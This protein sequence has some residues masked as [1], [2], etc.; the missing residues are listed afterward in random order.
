MRTLFICFAM[1]ALAVALPA[2]DDVVPETSQLT[3]DPQLQSSYNDAEATIA[4]LLQSGKDDSACAD[5]ATATKDEVTNSVDAQQKTLASMDN[6]DQCDGEGQSLIDAANSGKTAADQAKTDAATALAAAENE[7]FNFG[8]FSI[9]QLT[10]G[11]CGSFFNSG[12]YTAAKAKRDA[13]QQVVNTKNAEATAGDKEVED[14]KAAA[15]DLVKKCKC[16]TKE[17]VDK[18]LKEMNANAKDANQKAWNKAYHM[19]CVLAGTSPNDCSVPALPVVTA[20]PYGAGVKDACVQKVQ[21]IQNGC[22]LGGVPGQ[23]NCCKTTDA[24]KFACISDKKG[25]EYSGTTIVTEQTCTE[26]GLK[27]AL[28]KGADNGLFKGTVKGLYKIASGRSCTEL[29]VQQKG[30]CGWWEIIQPNVQAQGDYKDR[31]VTPWDCLQN[32]QWNVGGANPKPSDFANGNDKVKN[33]WTM[34]ICSK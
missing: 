26:K 30:G 16:K 5:L 10:E 7:K 27:F 18:A 2:A 28:V 32:A 4:S 6:G 22:E 20:V 31:C 3:G 9:N 33:T 23:P 14:A 34:S 17:S 11:Q 25:V 13:A 8:E 1:C 21:N 29:D 24:N 12:V 15:A 19:K